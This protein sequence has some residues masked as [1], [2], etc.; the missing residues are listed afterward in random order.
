MMLLRS[1]RS[2][3]AVFALLA[4]LH[5]LSLSSANVMIP[6]CSAHD[7]KCEFT[8]SVSHWSTMVYNPQSPGEAQ[9]N[10]CHPVIILPDG[11]ALGRHQSFEFCNITTPLDK[12][13]K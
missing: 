3:L 4:S 7:R 2:N 10:H 6:S 1:L 13:G 9:K 12:D 11:T 8:W 5:Q